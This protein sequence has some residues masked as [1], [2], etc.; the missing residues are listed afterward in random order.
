MTIQ[1]KPFLAAS[2]ILAAFRFFSM[3][4]RIFYNLAVQTNKVLVDPNFIDTLEQLMQSD[5]VVCF[6][7]D[8][9]IYELEA[10]RNTALGRMFAEKSIGV[11]VNSARWPNNCVIDYSNLKKPLDIS[12]KAIFVN[13]SLF[14]SL[15]AFWTKSEPEMSFHRSKSMFDMICVN[16][17]WKGLDR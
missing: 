16:F 5:L 12:G 6:S 11:G 13:F 9:A 1:P 4:L 2:I 10:D 14:K 7:E 8:Y 3:F 17:Y 15:L